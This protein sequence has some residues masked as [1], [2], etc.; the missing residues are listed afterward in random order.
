MCIVCGIEAGKQQKNCAKKPAV[1]AAAATLHHH[2]LTISI[3]SYHS[4]VVATLDLTEKAVV[5]RVLW[6][7]A[8]SS[9]QQPQSRTL[10]AYRPGVGTDPFA[11]QAQASQPPSTRPVHGTA[12][13]WWLMYVCVYARTHV[14]RRM[15]ASL[16]LSV[17][18][19]WL[20]LLGFIQAPLFSPG[21]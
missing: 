13:P 20:S 9:K 3:V 18:R 4:I 16:S 15:L 7:A 8:H 6:S 19:T 10:T 1:A 17:S 21:S 2:P 11:P 14:D 12:Y 5:I